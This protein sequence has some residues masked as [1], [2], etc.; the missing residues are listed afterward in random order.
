MFGFKELPE[1]DGV[2]NAVWLVSSRNKFVLPPKERKWTALD[3]L[4]L[5]TSRQ[6]ECIEFVLFKL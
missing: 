4:F 6:C 1:D 3:V 5:F 2:V